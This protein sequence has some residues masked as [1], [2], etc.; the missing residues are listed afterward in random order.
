MKDFLEKK[1]KSLSIDSTSQEMESDQ[2]DAA[3]LS[4]DED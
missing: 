4:G 3:E 2:L 1:K